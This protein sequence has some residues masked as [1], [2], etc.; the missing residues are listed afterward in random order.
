MSTRWF[1]DAMPRPAVNALTLPFFE[2][3]RE[4]RLIVHR[5]SSCHAYR[6]PPRPICPF[7]HSFDASWQE[8]DGRGRL[9]TW[10]VVH[11]QFHPA[12]AEILPYVV[13]VV[14]LDGT[15]GT[16]FTSNVV[17]ASPEDLRVGR[18]V[19]VVWED[20]DAHLTLPRFRLCR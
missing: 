12:T 18:P 13:A 10:S 11:Q 8:V 9:F 2:A 19:E 3:A 7:C 4:H 5:C 14:E 6:H 20:M 15:D 16:R 1:P 17:E